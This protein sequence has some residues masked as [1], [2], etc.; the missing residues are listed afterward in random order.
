MSKSKLTLAAIMILACG[1][2]MIA[3]TDG[4]EYPHAFPRA[5]VKKLLE[6]DRVM[7]WEVNWLKNVPQPTPAIVATWRVFISVTD[8][9]T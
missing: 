8:S 9:S 5:G 6:N 3:E 2:A 7:V 1:A 4:Q